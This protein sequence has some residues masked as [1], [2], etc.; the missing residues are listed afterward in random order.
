[1][2]RV[3][4]VFS[5]TRAIREFVKA[6]LDKNE[7][8]CGLVSIGEFFQNAILVPNLKKASQVQCL[9]VLKTACENTQNAHE[10]L[11]IA[12]EFFAFLKNSDYIF[13]FFKE[14]SRENVEISSLFEFDIYAN[15][16]EHLKILQNLYENYL[17]ELAKFG[18]YDDI[19]V[20]KFYQINEN[21]LQNFSQICINIDG[22]LSSFEWEIVQKTAAITQTLLKFKVSKFNQK[23]IKKISQISGL[24]FEENF[25]YCINLSQ[26]LVI[27]KTPLNPLPMINLSK[28][29]FSSLQAAFVMERIS[30]LVK[31]GVSA[32]KI[33]VILP[34]ENFTEI[35]KTHDKF[36]I[37]NYA[38]GESLKNHKF[39]KKLEI[40][41]DRA[42]F[43]DKNLSFY[44]IY[45]LKEFE[46]DENLYEFTNNIY[47]EV[48]D[49]EKFDEFMQMVKNG[50]KIDIELDEIIA[51]E[52]LFIKSLLSRSPLI[53]HQILELFLMRLAQISLSLA[54]GGE[55]V[56]QGVL[57]SRSL[58]YDAV[59]VVDFSDEFVPQRN[60][61]E[62]FLN[63]QIR[64]F[65]GLITKKEREDLQ[66]FYYTEL[67]RNAKNVYIS[68]VEN[69]MSVKSR[70]LDDL[71][72][73]ICEFYSENEYLNSLN[74]DKFPAKI[75]TYKKQ[76]II[77]YDFFENPLSFSRLDT[78]LS[79]E[80]MYYYKYIEKISAP[81]YGEKSDEFN[82]GNVLH[83][84]LKQYYEIYKN[85]FDKNKFF[86]IFTQNA[87]NC[88]SLEKEILRLNLDKFAKNENERF[89]NGWI[90]RD[91]EQNFSLK[92][93]NIIIE[94]RVDRI[95]VRSGE[96]CVIDYKSGKIPQN[97][98]QLAFYEALTSA[99]ESYFY[100]L[101][102]KFTLTKGSG[103][104][105]IDDLRE[106][107]QN[108]KNRAQNEIEFAQ[109][110]SKCGFCPYALMCQKE[111]V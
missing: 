73:Q 56:V 62:A 84:S 107:I 8:L 70:F 37:L 67:F 60:S 77:K 111:L 25:E 3:L 14:L 85:N 76:I 88:S 94:G 61:N 91:L 47:D 106:C 45:L 110:H 100:D 96:I 26:N 87:K 58:S 101:K 10:T 51:K 6:N 23:L 53:F 28:F 38:M 99:N 95:D 89:E 39:F 71:Q 33:V 93:E 50:I 108:L 13:S 49:F 66:R 40:L 68:Y 74:F 102:E 65:S 29:S 31:N 11:G 80:K 104:K 4:S 92:F 20:V 59:I 12:R 69:D 34:D 97:S 9:C 83:L 16:D 30:T 35:L 72:T 54:G 103:T 32:D 7:L 82:F 48:C 78:F 2:Q 42:N 98:Y 105:S 21:Y 109:N 5:T 43:S 52:M 86:E 27:S 57:E 75:N 18:F 41:K 24:R 81:S 63:S 55:V 64:S 22:I 46:I 17:L 90:V 19:N 1:M 36:G 15:F 79:C 44:Q